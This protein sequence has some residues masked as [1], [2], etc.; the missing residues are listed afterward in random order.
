MKFNKSNV[1]E[2]VKEVRD[3]APLS[4]RVMSTGHSGKPSFESIVKYNDLSYETII[5]ENRK[6]NALIVFGNDR[7]PGAEWNFKKDKSASEQGFGNVGA[8][9]CSSIDIVAGLGGV[10]A[11]PK[12]P[13]T[14]TVLRDAARIYISEMTDIDSAFHISTNA[15]SGVDAYYHNS[16]GKSAVGVSADHVR[17]TANNCMKLVTGIRLQDSKQRGL[18]FIG[19]SGGIYLIA[20]NDDADLQ[21]IPKGDNLVDF[22]NTLIK[23]FKDVLSVLT[24]TTMAV[25]DLS[26]EVMNHYHTSPFR[27]GGTPLPTDSGILSC[28]VGIDT[29][30]TTNEILLSK[31]TM[32]NINI[33]EMEAKYLNPAMN[34]SD[35][36]GEQKSNPKYILSRRNKVN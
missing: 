6:N 8:A 33:A 14:P 15:A 36:Q 10:G 24:D 7:L 32:L 28:G 27:P 9:G 18:E 26:Q 21:F 19:Q 16:Y 4:Q 29:M 30:A 1:F 25:K 22:A 35:K 17:I 12:K 5:P 13:Y 31:I 11:N 23:N 2:N 34:I 3:L 20:G